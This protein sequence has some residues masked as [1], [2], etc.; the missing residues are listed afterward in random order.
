MTYK[1]TKEVD[2][3]YDLT[4]Q[5]AMQIPHSLSAGLQLHPRARDRAKVRIT[6]D[7]K[8]GQELAKIIKAKVADIDIYS[9]RTLFDWRIS[10]NVE[11]DFNIDKS[12]LVEV[13][14]KDGRAADRRKDRVSYKHLAYQI[15]LTQVASAEVST[16]LTP[17]RHCHHETAP[18]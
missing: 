13:E 1:H 17:A 2:R 18:C 4:Q 3:F 6:T 5:G 15:D 8:T 12:E 10:V 9:P 14:R 16:I 7:E 11:I